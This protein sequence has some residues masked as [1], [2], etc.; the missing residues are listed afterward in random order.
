MVFNN[1]TD[2]QDLVSDIHFWC[3]TDEDTYPLVDIVR[4]YAFGLGKTSARIMRCDRTWKHVSNNINAIPIAT[5][6]FTAGQDNISFATKHLKI[7]RVRITDNA[8]VLYTLPA[9][10]RK[11]FSDSVLNN[12]GTPEGYDKIGGSLMPIPVPSYG[13]TIEIEYQPGAAVDVPGV[14]GSD[15][16]EVGFNQDFERLPGLYVSED[17]CAL[18]APERLT[19]IRAKILELETLM[20]N[21]FESRDIDDEPALEIEKTSKGPSLLYGV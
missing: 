1:E 10:D 5:Q 15:D 6:T 21:Y 4:N 8:G 16:W 19:A 7:L 11:K 17:Y 13:G 2:N 9:A 20:D 12:P 18:H 3:S 14:T